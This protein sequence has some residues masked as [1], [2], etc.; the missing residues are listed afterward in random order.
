M[1]ND[2]PRSVPHIL[3]S[4]SFSPYAHAGDFCPLRR[5]ARTFSGRGRSCCS[6]WGLCRMSSFLFF[7]FTCGRSFVKRLNYVESQQLD[8]GDRWR[9]ATASDV[10][11]IDCNRRV[12]CNRGHLRREPQWL[13]RRPRRKVELK[14]ITE[15]V[16][17]HPRE[18]TQ[19]GEWSY[20][21]SACRDHHERKWIQ[22]RLLL[23]PLLDCAR[24]CFL[25]QREVRATNTQRKKQADLEQEPIEGVSKPI[26]CETAESG[27][28]GRSLYG[29]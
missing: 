9:A 24:K 28:I 16:E 13:R 25:L 11:S 21:G 3:G 1:T 12:C 14:E 27:R 5:C 29:V 18:R 7:T 17:I 19:S 26:R 2:C 20:S 22:T 10:N 8:S 15:A 4:A 23:L 6:S